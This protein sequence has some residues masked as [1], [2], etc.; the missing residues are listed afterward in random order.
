[1]GRIMK[2]AGTPPTISR[3]GTGGWQIRAALA[4]TS[5]YSYVLMEWLFF[6]TKPS[7]MSTLG[8]LDLLSVLF[9]P[10]LLFAV[11]GFV[12]VIVLL[13]PARLI[14]NRFVGAFLGVVAL[15]LPAVILGSAFL[16]MV[17]NFTYTIFHFG[18]RNT[19]GPS[20]LVYGV[21]FVVLV[22]IAY[23]ILSGIVR[24]SERPLIRRLFTLVA[25][26]IV[27]VSVTL[28]IAWYLTGGSIPSESHV[29][30]IAA[31]RRPNI[32]IISSDGLN[33][34]NMS[35]YGYHRET[36]PFLGGIIDIA[37]LCENNFTNSGA[38]AGSIASI[39]TG[40]LPT[41][42]RMLYTPDILK[43][44]DAYEH[45]PGMLRRLGYRNIEISVRHHTD[46]YDMNM[47]N[48]FDEA[49]R[50]KMEIGSTPA[51]VS[52]VLGQEPSYFLGRMYDRISDRLLHAFLVSDMV[53]PF[54]EV[55]KSGKK[56]T[57]DV[58]RI[59]DL[60]E[61]IG[62]SPEPFFAHLHLLG[63]HGP[64][65][66]IRKQVFSLGQVQEERWMTD[67]YDDAI[68][69]FDGQV[70]EIFAGLERKGMLAN[71]VIVICSDHGQ[72][73]SF[74][75]RLPL[76][77]F[78]PGGEHSGRIRPNTQNLDIAPTLLD[79]LGLDPPDWMEG[80]SL[81]SSE[82]GLDRVIFVAD[83]RHDMQNRRLRLRRLRPNPFG[84]PFYSLGYIGAVYCQRLYGLDLVGNSFTVSDLEGHTAPCSESEMPPK[85][86]MRRLII[87]HLDECGYDTSS[88]EAAL[89]T[90][91]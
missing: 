50:R 45:L 2:R 25:A 48:A 6:V 26:G 34:G 68:L 62:R 65:F 55:V 21:L 58:H 63:T 78:F 66:G 90:R 42:T 54:A 88:I 9:L 22:A 67:F 82:P 27:A 79:Y 60:F 76:I 35:V 75:R 3:Y 71:T 47:R 44:K 18:V 11:G 4:V 1:M 61:F 12:V 31:A 86:E 64:Q 69:E 23:L 52:E 46:P 5:I 24:A 7:F 56:Y 19:S 59:V 85:E 72:G 40:K 70:D 28:A 84:P 30:G 33:A 89:D 14:P 16:L 91:R 83:R 10:P 38:S 53:D 37:L 41:R 29:Q 20:R 81:V 73:W 36:T 57:T 32:L 43:G 8:S 49:N 51:L 77:F 13:A 39:L 87:D 15:V 74:D 17:D 80:M